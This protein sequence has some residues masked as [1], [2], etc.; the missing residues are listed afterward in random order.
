MMDLTVEIQGDAASLEECLDLFTAR[1][2]LHGDNMY[3]C[4]GCNDYVLA[5]KRLSIRRAPNVLT[6]ALKRFQSGRFGK[7]NKRVTFPETLDIT[8]YMSE[9]GDGNDVYKLY[10]V[11]VHVDMLNASFFGHYICYTKDFRG[12]WYRID[13]CKVNLAD[14]DEVL[15]QGAYMLLYS[16]VCPRP[17]CLYPSEP[18]KE[19]QGMVK[20]V[21]EGEHFRKQPVECFSAAEVTD[22]ARVSAS[23]SSDG[24]SVLKVSNCKDESTSIISPEYIKEDLD[25]M[26]IGP[27]SS[28]SKDV[29]NGCCNAVKEIAS[30]VKHA[31]RLVSGVTSLDD[32]YSTEANILQHKPLSRMLDAENGNG[33]SKNSAKHC[34]EMD[35]LT[36][37]SVSTQKNVCENGE[38]PHK[39]SVAALT[40][41]DVRHEENCV[42]S[43]AK[44][45]KV[46]S[47][48]DVQSSSGS[49]DSAGKL[50]GS[51][52]RAKLKPL[53]PPGFLGKRTR[54]KYIK[55]DGKVLAEFSEPVSACNAN[56]QKNDT[57][58]PNS[59]HQNGS[60]SSI[61]LQKQSGI[62]DDWPLVGEEIPA[63]NGNFLEP[64]ETKPPRQTETK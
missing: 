45:E 34:V 26:D 52:T 44:P 24:S 2:P 6:I 50:D 9:T 28:V 20:I 33:S 10:A 37:F 22:T 23:L 32:S 18:L 17:S 31:H 25:T 35:S 57:Y 21:Q 51:N 56:C 36:A 61:I 60:P 12:N 8:P 46:E 40:P 43:R 49:E 48:K 27:S 39:N 47:G 53:F 15:S 7:L 11:V 59:C 38:T 19:E 16:R 5:W 14:L 42:N 13:D 58:S 3:K 64:L 29:G 62:K 41:D 1:E 54:G 4:D 30:P 55:R 63:G